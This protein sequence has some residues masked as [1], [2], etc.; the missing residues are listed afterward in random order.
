MI[1]NGWM[2]SESCDSGGMVHN[3]VNLDQETRDNLEKGGGT[4]AATK[5]IRASFSAS[6]SS[7]I[8]SNEKFFR[9][10]SLKPYT[11]WQ[12]LR[13]AEQSPVG[14]M[15]LGE[16]VEAGRDIEV[17]RQVWQCMVSAGLTSNLLGPLRQPCRRADLAG[18]PVLLPQHHHHGPRLLRLHGAAPAVLLPL[19]L[20]PGLLRAQLV[21]YY[22]ESVLLVLY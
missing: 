20:P 6:I 9:D 16:M 11:G 7:F 4:K 10:G 22:V 15:T 3:L 5:M 2:F 21:F 14:P 1:V 17:A 13:Q 19:R 8:S 18:G 12:E